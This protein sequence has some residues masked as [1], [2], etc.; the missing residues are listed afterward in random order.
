MTGRVLALVAALLAGACAE[1]TTGPRALTSSAPATRDPGLRYEATVTVLSSEKHGPQLCAGAML[2]SLPPQCGGPDVTPWDWAKVDGEETVSGTS[3]G[4]FHLVGTFDGTTF[5]LTEP[6]GPPRRVSATPNPG[7]AVPCAE[8]APGGD[9]A[10]RSDEDQ[11][12]AISHARAQGDFAGAWLGDRASTVVLAF[13]GD[14]ARHE[15]EARERWGGPLCVT[16]LPR[17]F[18]SLK[19]AQD[20]LRDAH[21]EAKAAGVVLLSTSVDEYANDVEVGLLVAD[22][23]ARAW[24]DAKIGPGLAR[25]T[26]VLKPLDAG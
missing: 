18:A 22:A 7:F 19:R 23:Q 25:V 9:P 16:R 13:T 11:N 6:P 5:R 14:L 20:A 17:T 26:G 4:K 24:I 10:R 21:E 3:W 8:A 12:A 1:P 2:Y 15:R